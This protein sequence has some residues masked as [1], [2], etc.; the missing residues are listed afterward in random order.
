MPIVRTNDVETYYEVRGSGP[1]MVFVHGAALDHAQWD[2]Q[3][4]ALSDDYETFAY[5]VRGHGRTGGSARGRY[6]MALF[7]DDLDAFVSEL[8]IEK[9]ILCGISMGGCIAQVY[10]AA[11]PD[12]L[13]GL[14]LADT[15]TPE[16]TSL[17]EWVQRSL[18]LRA[19]IPPARLV[20]YERVER[21]IAWLQERISGP[22]VSGEYEKIQRLRAERPK[23][24]TEEFAKV[25]R[26][27]AAFHET[28]IDLGAIAVPT[29]ILYGENEAPFLRRHVPKLSAELPNVTVREIPNAGHASNLDNPEAFTQA[30][31]EFLT[32]VRTWA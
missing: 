27:L 20:G 14:V 17:G 4:E 26:A 31:E 12:R 3:V 7:A 13:A 9:P 18:M 10:A 11:Y 5:D 16:L 22:G 8:G 25:I 30:I 1:P 23:M 29:L 21:A 2:P 6:S 24:E 28:E 32:Q 19:A 15:F